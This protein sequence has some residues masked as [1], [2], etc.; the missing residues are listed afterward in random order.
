MIV[1]SRSTFIAYELTDAETKSAYTYNEAQRAGIQNQIAL[2]AEEILRI[3]LDVDDTDVADIK[4]RA[5]LRGKIA[6]GKYLLELHDS[7]N[8][9]QEGN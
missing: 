5:F 1:N 7:F 6:F 8:Q 3:P 4:R 9:P 2:D